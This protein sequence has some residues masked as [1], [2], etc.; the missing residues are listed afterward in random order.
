[1]RSTASCRASESCAASIRS[2]QPLETEPPPFDRAVACRRVA[3]V[4][5]M[6]GLGGGL[7]FPILPALGLKL[8]IAGAMIGL[9]LSANRIT[10][11]AFA[12]WAGRIVDRLGG[13]TPL[14]L[15]LLVEGLGILGYEAALLF[16]HAAWWFLAGRAIFGIGSALLLVGAQATVLRYSEVSD[17]GRYA[18]SV[19]I[20]MSM[21]MPG[22]LVMGGLIADRISDGAAFLTGAGLTALGATIALCFVPGAQAKAETGSSIPKSTPKLSL[23]ELLRTP[24]FP[25]LAAAWG[26]N[27]L[28]FLSVQ[29][30]LLATLVLLVEKRG[31]HLFGLAGEGTA[32]LVMAVMMACASVLA[33]FIGH[34]L[35]RIAMRT[36]PLLPCLMGLST[37]FILLGVS[38]SLT[39]TLAGVALTGIS[40]NGITLPLLTLLGDITR[41]E[42]Y[43]RAVGTYQI[44]GD[45]GG[46]LGPILG[47]EASLHFG[48]RTTYL[49]VAALLILSIPA[50]WWVCRRETVHRKNGWV[51]GG[52]FP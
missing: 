40:F 51:A 5:F 41:P 17:R 39:T 2:S 15:G 34:L 18:A 11:L 14:S 13:K 35:D 25:F 37:G 4:T 29:G 8:G 32:G 9:I 42:R 38:R 27:L 48:L 12:S 28:V 16:G 22:G 33:L 23:R 31:F 52:F 45:I 19:R 3:W 10:R 49:G 24:E 46:S 44:F 21:G 1:M 26:F 36:I 20:A 30:V 47:L 7:V 6:G 50:A 43:G